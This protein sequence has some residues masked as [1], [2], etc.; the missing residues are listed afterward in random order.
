MTYK[1][2]YKIWEFLLLIEKIC[3]EPDKSHQ[4]R[5]IL[6]RLSLQRNSNTT[7]KSAEILC[8]FCLQHWYQME[9]LIKY[10]HDFCTNKCILLFDTE[11]FKASNLNSAIKTLL[12]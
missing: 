10:F 8:L 3:I 7:N 9:V 2:N 4:N 11:Y 6:Q 1:S 12:R 5:E